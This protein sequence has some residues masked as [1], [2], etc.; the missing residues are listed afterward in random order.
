VLDTLRVDDAR[1]FGWTPAQYLCVL[2]TIA[3]V[4]MVVWSLRNQRREASA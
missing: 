3:G 4:A 1:Y 2:M